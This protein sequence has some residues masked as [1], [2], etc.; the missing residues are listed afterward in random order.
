MT[1]DLP[2]NR[3][4]VWSPVASALT[5]FGIGS[6]VGIVLG[7]V[8]LNQIQVHRQRGRWLALAGIVLGAVTLLVSMFV[9]ID[10]FVAR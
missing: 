2:R 5:L 9:V 7:V 4:A 6:I 10:V 1:D 8:A 3:L